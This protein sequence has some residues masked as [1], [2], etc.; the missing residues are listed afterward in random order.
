MGLLLARLFVC[1]RSLHGAL[2]TI[3][4]NSRNE[5][6]LVAPRVIDMC[7]NTPRLESGKRDAFDV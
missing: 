1:P 7:F 5:S 6:N 3:V 2:K 4:L